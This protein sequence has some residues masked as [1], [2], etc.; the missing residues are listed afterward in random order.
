MPQSRN[1]YFG[2]F[3]NY[4]R[5]CKGIFHTPYPEIGA[6]FV[7]RSAG[8]RLAHQPQVDCVRRTPDC[9]RPLRA[10]LHGKGNA[11]RSS[12]P[13]LRDL[14]RL[15]SNVFVSQPTDRIVSCRVAPRFIF[16]MTCMILLA[17]LHAAHQFGR[18]SYRIYTWFPPPLDISQ[19]FI[20]S[21]CKH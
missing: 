9:C 14:V 2:H 17:G 21:S 19:P 1:T 13:Q 10:T 16:D 7:S 6:T 3:A 12:V 11:S 8:A 15:V 5:F 20:L 4:R 18:I